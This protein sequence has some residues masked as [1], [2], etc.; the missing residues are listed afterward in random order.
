MKKIK[1]IVT[2]A[3]VG[4][5]LMGNIVYAKTFSDVTAKGDYQWIYSSLDKLSNQGVFGGYPDGTF[6][7]KRAVSFLEIMQ[8]IKNIKNPSTEE[9][10]SARDT[11]K[12]EVEKY[13]IDSWAVDAVC[14]NLKNNTITAKTLQAANDKGFLKEKNKLYPDRNSVAVYFGR[15]LKLNE[16]GNRDLLKHSDANS[17]PDMTKGYLGSLVEANIFSST[18]SNGKFNGSKYISRAEVASIADKALVYL[19]N[20]NVEV[21]NIEDEKKVEVEDLISNRT[22]VEGI[23]DYIGHSNSV[24]TIGINSKTYSFD[25]DTIKIV[26]ST[27]LYSGDFSVINKMQV[28]AVVNES[29]VIELYLLSMPV[30]VKNV[31]ITGKVTSIS[32][33]GAEYTLNLQVLV[34]DSPNFTPGSTVSVNTGNSYKVDDILNISA[35][36][37]NSQL[38]DIKIK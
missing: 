9:V 6:K 12:S 29:E 8:V 15:A 13:K 34:S 28:R 14:Y 31:N 7:P 25:A 24:G 26:D 35:E 19:E 16:N 2:V 21:K 38:V 30:E 3:L 4:T 22:E 27:G 10:Q 32:S 18:G 20:H 33:N 11:Y 5:V 36:Y 1:K 37:K 23:V 17:I